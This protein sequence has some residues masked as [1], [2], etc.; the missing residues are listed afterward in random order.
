[1]NTTPNEGRQGGLVWHHEQAQ[2]PRHPRTLFFFCEAP[3]AAGCGGATGLAP[4]AAVHDALAAEHPA[5]L[6]A[7]AARGLVYRAALPPR[8]GAGESGVGRSWRSFW[9]CQTRAQAEARMRELGYSFVWEAPAGG[10]GEEALLRMTTPAL[11]AVVQASGRR[12][13]FNQAV[14]QALS[15]AACFA[16]VAEGGGGGGGGPPLSDFMTLGDGSPVDLEALRCAARAADEHG[17]DVQWQCGDV[18]LID[19]YLVMHAR[20]PW[21]GDGPRRVLASLV[22]EPAAPLP[23]AGAVVNPPAAQRDGLCGQ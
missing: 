18:A 16:A 20:R 15:N 13:F 6:A 5:F 10:E 8:D 2:A 22:N 11:P 17:Y 7:A 4:S 3:A 19:N 23:V 21:T 1:M 14:A 12:C 9:R